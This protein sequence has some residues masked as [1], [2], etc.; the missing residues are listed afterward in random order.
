MKKIHILSLTTLF[1]LLFM[2]PVQAQRGYIKNKIKKNVQ[3]DMK[4]KHAEPQRK[5]GKE[6]LEDITYENDTRY[7]VPENPV[8]ATMVIETK[9]FKKNGKLDDS[10]T[11]KIVFGN[12]GECVIMNEGE[13]DEARMLYDY[14]GAAT[15]VVNEKEKTAMKMPMI[16][17]QKMMEGM[18]KSNFGSESTDSGT[19]QRTNEQKEI[20]GFMC[21]KYIYTNPEEKTKVD[22]W[23]T[24]DIDIDLSGNHLFGGQIKD[25][26]K[27]MAVEKASADPNLPQGM[28]VRSVQYEKN[29]ETPS[30]QV[31]IVTFNKSSDP[32]YF[33]LSDYTVTDVLGKL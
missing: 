30:A 32:K 23:T 9:S 16:N 31:D 18:A 8:Q 11:S 3:S 19:W 7:P 1:L 24:Q 13:K 6:A 17:F 4:E 12:T 14:K 27:M 29:R 22:I 33:D 5:K 21:R 25:F 28:L 20:N 15:Y 2:V 10:A 26:S